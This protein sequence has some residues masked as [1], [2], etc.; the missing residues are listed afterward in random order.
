MS[1][2][3]QFIKIPALATEAFQS[4]QTKKVRATKEVGG[5]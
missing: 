2:L 4:G 1:E 3:N 5:F